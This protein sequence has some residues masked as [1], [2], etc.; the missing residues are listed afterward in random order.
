M[1]RRIFFDASLIG[2]ARVLERHDDGIIYP[3]HPEWLHSQDVADEV[4]LRYVGERGWCAILRD[5]RIRYR[6]PQ[7]AA[8]QAYRVRAVVIATSRNLSVEE[9]AALLL[10]HWDYIKESLDDPPSYMHLTQAGLKVM[11]EYDQEGETNGAEEEP[12]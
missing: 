4:W 12:R 9:N 2:V 5:K 11:L 1:N 8:L 3:G 10:R 7:Q 6:L